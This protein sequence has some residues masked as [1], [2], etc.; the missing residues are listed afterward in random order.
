MDKRRQ[1]GNQL[2]IVA[3]IFE[4]VVEFQLLDTMIGI[5][6]R[7]SVVFAGLLPAIVACGEDQLVPAVDHL[8]LL[9]GKDGHLALLNDPVC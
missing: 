4:D 1:F 6:P 7:F 2:N 3:T 8:V 9:D 5:G